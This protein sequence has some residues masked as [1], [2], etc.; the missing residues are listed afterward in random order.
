[1]GFFVVSATG[2]FVLV[3]GFTTECRELD[4]V[5]SFKPLATGLPVLVRSKVEL[6]AFECL[7]AV[8]CTRHQT[9][10]LV[11]SSQPHVPLLLVFLPVSASWT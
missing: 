7:R 8:R 11:L 6:C 2:L 3:F 10:T 9:T 5:F 1:M 4:A